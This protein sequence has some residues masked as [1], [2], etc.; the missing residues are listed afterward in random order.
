[1]DNKDSSRE[2][3]QQV[4]A[5][6]AAL[7]KCKGIAAR[8]RQMYREHLAA[9]ALLMLTLGVVISSPPM[10]AQR[11]VMSPTRKAITVLR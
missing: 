10:Q 9:V 4:E 7:V 6:K 3:E 5:L 2:T 11:A 8:G 1:M